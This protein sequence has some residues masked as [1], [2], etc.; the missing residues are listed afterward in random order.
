MN[1]EKANLPS[2]KNIECRTL[3]IETNIINQKLP[4][5]VTNNI[6]ELNVLIYTA[7][8]LVYEKIGIFSNSTKKQSKP[9]WEIRQETQIKQSTKRS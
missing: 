8:K 7:A 3:K 1:S 9:G 2:L 4:Y 5:V 6:T